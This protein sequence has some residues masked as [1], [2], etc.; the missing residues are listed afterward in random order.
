MTMT[1]CIKALLI[2]NMKECKEEETRLRPRP[3]IGWNIGSG[4]HRCYPAGWWVNPESKWCQLYWIYADDRHTNH[5]CEGYIGITKNDLKVRWSKKA[6]A[7]FEAEWERKF[8][9]AK[10]RGW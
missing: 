5:E 9:T 10:D 1:T 7:N 4:G 8:K 2:S 3:L 6:L